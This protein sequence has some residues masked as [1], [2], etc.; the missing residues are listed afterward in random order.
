L[1]GYGTRWLEA[2]MTAKMSIIPET[3]YPEYGRSE[4]IVR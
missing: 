2:E 4:E 3:G 1:V